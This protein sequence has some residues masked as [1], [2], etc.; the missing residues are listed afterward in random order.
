[1]GFN[2]YAQL[3]GRQPFSVPESEEGTFVLE[4]WNGARLTCHTEKEQIFVQDWNAFFA[5]PMTDHR[6]R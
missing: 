1:M 4:N 6:D 2:Q 3:M 5:L